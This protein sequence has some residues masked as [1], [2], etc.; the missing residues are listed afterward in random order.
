MC[1]CVCV[2]YLLAISFLCF[3][4]H[5]DE[6]ISDL[7][8]ISSS[9]IIRLLSMASFAICEYTNQQS[10]SLQKKFQGSNAVSNLTYIPI[11]PFV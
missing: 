3:C 5:R 8:S 7:I 2:C 6:T 9:S 1:V 4:V 11:V 10:K